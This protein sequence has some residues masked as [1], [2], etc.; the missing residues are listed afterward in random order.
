L[1]HFQIELPVQLRTGEARSFRM[2]AAPH[3]EPGGYTVWNGTIT[4]ITEQ[5]RAEEQIRRLNADLERRVAERTADLARANA[6]LQAEIAERALLEA[7]LGQHAERATALAELSRTLAEASLDMQ[8]LFEPITRQ[9][10]RSLGDAC[11]LAMLSDDR[12]LLE[13][14]AIGH[15]D[16]ERVAFMRT[17][18]SSA[19][20]AHE[21]L[22]GQVATASQAALVP[23]ISIEQ[24]RARLRPEYRS[25][26]ERFGMACLLIVPVRA[27]GRVIGTLGISRDQAGYSYSAHDQAF[28]QDLADRAGLAIENARLFAS[29]QQARGEAERANR[30]KSAFLSSMSHE[31]RTPL[32]AIIGFTG[33]LLMQLPGPL[34]ADQQQQ[35]STVQRSGRH[36]LSLINDLLDLAKIESGRSELLLEPLVCQDVLAEVAS[37]LRV[38]AE[39][40]Q[41]RLMLDMAEAPLQ[42]VSDRRALRQILANL[43]DNAIKFSDAGEVTLSLTASQEPAAVCF[44]VRDTGIGIA[45]EDLERLFTEFGRVNS[46]AVRARE[47]TGLG[48]RLSRTLAALLGGTIDVA[49]APGVGSTFTLRL[50]RA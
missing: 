38:L 43:V 15:P 40:K 45:A 11:V 25:Y 49:S 7:R 32:N 12:Q 13:V 6:E 14:V 30:A 41:L 3:R 20:P 39:Q 18:L 37:D 46:A 31:L 42:L 19:R 44:A 50:P 35:L 4:D 29:E 24:A 26:A 16:A 9:I 10:A 47:G 34:N 1:A 22:A 48:L 21:G 27:R 28:L 23:S 17:M 8:P 36:L 5:A 33:T 2:S